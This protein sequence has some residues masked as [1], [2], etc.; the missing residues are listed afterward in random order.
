MNVYI[1]VTTIDIEMFTF[2]TLFPQTKAL[3]NS[4][5]TEWGKMADSVVK[6]NISGRKRRKSS[7]VDDEREEGESVFCVF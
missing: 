4:D 1:I 3:N 2:P 6:R 5:A 7:V